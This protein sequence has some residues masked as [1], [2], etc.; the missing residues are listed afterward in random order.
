M[1]GWC[2]KY[3]GWHV[4][5]GLPNI[6]DDLLS[7]WILKQLDNFVIIDD[8]ERITDIYILLEKQIT[9]FLFIVDT[10][11][12]FL[13]YLDNALPN[14]LDSSIQEAKI[15]SDHLQQLNQ[16]ARGLDHIQCEDQNIATALVFDAL[17]NGLQELNSLFI[18]HL[19]DES[20]E[21]VCLGFEHTIG[22]R[23]GINEKSDYLAD[24]SIDQQEV[25]SV[26]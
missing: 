17:F 18:F 8:I 10:I 20:L 12:V 5:F 7:I 24:A 25:L 2:R 4:I 14:F 21:Q 11:H 9:H 3:R 16:Q 23:E 22:F 19:R 15:V 13:G 1:H 26:Q 6:H